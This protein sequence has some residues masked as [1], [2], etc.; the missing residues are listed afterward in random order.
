MHVHKEE[1]GGEKTNR[2][3][4]PNSE[5]APNFRSPMVPRYAQDQWRLPLALALPPSLPLSLPLPLPPPTKSLQKPQ[6]ATRGDGG[7]SAGGTRPVA[8]YPAC[9]CPAE[10]LRSTALAAPPP[11]SSAAGLISPEKF[12]SSHTSPDEP[13][14]RNVSLDRCSPAMHQRDKES[15]LARACASVDGD[16]RGRGRAGVELVCSG[17]GRCR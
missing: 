5:R 1:G 16:R 10:R 17:A 14:R 6:T 3:K 9:A 11:S 13:D 8:L 2:R 15:P 12:L 7:S 4:R